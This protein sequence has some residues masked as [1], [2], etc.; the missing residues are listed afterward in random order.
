MRLY[1]VRTRK[2]EGFTLAEALIALAVC[3]L[4]GVAVFAT[5]QRLLLA[6]KAQRETTAASMMLQE[7]M[8]AFRGIYFA[9]LAATTASG[10]T[11]PITMTAGDIV[12][13]VTTS[14]TQLGSSLTETV[15]V[16]GYW[17]STGS[18]GYPS[19]GSIA[20]TW[21]RS[22]GST[23]A[24]LSVPSNSTLASN[25]DLIQVDITLTW[26]SANGRQRTRELSSVFGKGNIGVSL[27]SNS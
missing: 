11:S 17:T 4:F 9:N 8:E 18:Q 3:V 6:L 13:T 21:T 26:T 10:T 5:N 7:R 25:Y 22:G 19:D 23:T 1:P 14:E 24:T 27:N 20:N 12:G 2:T 15:K 16:S